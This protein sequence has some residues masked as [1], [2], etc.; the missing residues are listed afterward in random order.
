[1]LCK[2]LYKLKDCTKEHK[3]SFLDNKTSVTKLDPTAWINQYS[4]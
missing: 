2:V 3:D 1:M 4:D